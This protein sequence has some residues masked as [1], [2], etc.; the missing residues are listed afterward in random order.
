MTEKYR[1]Q[2]PTLR[3]AK[4]N[5][6][7]PKNPYA[8]PHLA[9]VRKATDLNPNSNQK[10]TAS[11]VLARM[12]AAVQQRQSKI[13]REEAG[14]DHI[15]HVTHTKHVDKIQKHGILPMKTSN[16][17]KAGNKER[18]GGGEVYAFTHRADAEAWAG[19]MDWANH[20]KIG[21]GNI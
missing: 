21:S 17:V 16:W 8:T 14:E 7:V 19:R 4:T 10:L 12:I 15:Y 1:S 2:Y 9:W 20:Q 5:W 6:S 18:Y 3:Q 13:V 11:A